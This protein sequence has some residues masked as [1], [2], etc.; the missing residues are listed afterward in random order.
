[1]TIETAAVMENNMQRNEPMEISNDV[2]Q[3]QVITEKQIEYSTKE[4][5]NF[6]PNSGV[7]PMLQKAQ[8]MPV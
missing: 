4:N 1:M 2:K 5:S 8:S 7:P 6:A 3:L